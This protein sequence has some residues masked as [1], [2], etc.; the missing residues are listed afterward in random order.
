M[1]FFYDIKLLYEQGYHK[2]MQVI[3]DAVRFLMR[4]Y[5]R[6]PGFF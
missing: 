4:R 2:E 1:L 3:G 6:C 5:L